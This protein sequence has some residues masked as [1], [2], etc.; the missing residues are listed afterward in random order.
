MKRLILMLCALVAS[1]MVMACGE[2]AKSSAEQEGVTSESVTPIASYKQGCVVT[3]NGSTIDLPY[4]CRQ[5]IVVDTSTRKDCVVHTL[6]CDTDT[7][8]GSYVAGVIGYG[9]LASA[10]TKREGDGKTP[11]GTFALRRGLYYVKDFHTSFPMEQYNENYTWDENPVSPT[12][13]TLLRNPKPGTKGDRIWEHRNRQYRYIVVV[14]YNTDQ[15]IPGAGSAIFIHAWRAAGKP[16]AGC[17]G[18]SE[19]NMKRVVEWLDPAKNPHIV[20]LPKGVHFSNVI[21]K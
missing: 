10:G 11:V 4:G 9:G 7:W 2:S 1:C 12:Y 6:S 20:V 5:V 8:S 16:T 18:M 15:P 21:N 3:T 13:N 19:A 14:E 17:V